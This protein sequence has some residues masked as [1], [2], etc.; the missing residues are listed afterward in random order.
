MKTASRLIHALS[1]SAAFGMLTDCSAS[2]SPVASIGAIPP[3]VTLPTESKATWM[4]PEAKS[5]DLLYLD[6]GG[7]VS[8]SSYPENK[9]VGTFGGGPGGICPDRNGD[10]WITNYYGG[11][12]VEYAHGGKVPISTLT[13]PGI[14]P[15]GCSIDPT[16]GNLA[17]VGYGP[18]NPN[19]RGR[20]FVYTG[21]AGKPKIFR[22]G[23]LVTSFCGYDNEGNL[24][25]DGFGWGEQ[26]PFAFGEIRKGGKRFKRISLRG[27]SYPGPVQW[28]G[29]YLAVASDDSDIM[30]RYD[31][32]GNKAV[33]VGGSIVLGG[34]DYVNAA[35]IQG[36]TIIETGRGDATSQVFFYDYP[37]GGQPSST[38]GG[39]SEQSGVSVS[40]APK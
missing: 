18:E 15:Q 24:F 6:G 19:V 21:A 32:R 39:L 9:L 26:P 37:A 28:D 27:L 35:W 5:E 23:F 29:K 36:S 1:L 7:S 22:T 40:L 13:T 34:G 16:S 3:G 8:V 31:I 38:I 14:S 10:V 4:L 30:N 12:I 17:V 33:Q 11:T 25:I 2:Q 20:I